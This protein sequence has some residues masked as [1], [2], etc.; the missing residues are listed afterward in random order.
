M[1]SASLSDWPERFESKPLSSPCSDFQ[2][3]V[4]NCMGHHMLGH[5]DLIVKMFFVDTGYLMM[6]LYCYIRSDF[7]KA[8]IGSS[9]ASIIIS[10]DQK[11]F[12]HE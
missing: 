5:Q 1:E 4:P 2:V 10:Q 8:T 6:I 11:Y 9:Q 3:A 12:L 7:Q